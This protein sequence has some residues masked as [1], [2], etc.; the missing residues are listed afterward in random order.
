MFINQSNLSFFHNIAI[1]IVN[2]T[3]TQNVNI[4]SSPTLTSFIQFRLA[5]LKSPLFTGDPGLGFLLSPP[6]PLSP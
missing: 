5:G 1:K 3:A 4:H 2:T 6:F